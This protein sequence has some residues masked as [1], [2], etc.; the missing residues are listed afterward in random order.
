MRSLY[1]LTAVTLVAA[2]ITTVAIADFCRRHSQS[3]VWEAGNSQVATSSP[4]QCYNK[5]SIYPGEPSS[6]PPAC[7]APT[8]AYAN[9][10]PAYVTPSP[11]YSSASVPAIPPPPVNIEGVPEHK[12]LR[13]EALKNLASMQPE[14]PALPTARGCRHHR[15]PGAMS[16]GSAKSGAARSW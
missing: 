7:S 13:E 5:T 8:Y 1:W 4:A 15:Q 16:L 12:Q 3:A 2:A 10:P 9:T 6:S 14:P 11:T